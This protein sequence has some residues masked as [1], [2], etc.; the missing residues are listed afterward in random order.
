MTSATCASAARA[1][2]PAAPP[3]TPRQR[4]RRRRRSAPLPSPRLPRQRCAG[5]GRTMGATAAP[6]TEKSTATA[7]A[8]CVA[9]A[10][11]ATLVILVTL[12]TFPTLKTCA[13]LAICA[14]PSMPTATTAS[15]WTTATDP[16][17]AVARAASREAVPTRRGGTHARRS[18]SGNRL[19]LATR[20]AVCRGISQM[21]ADGRPSAR[22]TATPTMP[23]SSASGL[24]ASA[25][26]PLAGPRHRRGSLLR[27]PPRW[28]P[29]PW[30]VAL[31]GLCLPVPRGGAIAAAR[32]CLAP[33]AVA[34]QPQRPTSTT[35]TPMP[36]TT[37]PRVATAGPRQPHPGLRRLRSSCARRR[38]FPV[39]ARP[40]RRPSTC[41][42][43]T[44]GV[45]LANLLLAAHGRVVSL[46]ATCRTLMMM[47]W[48]TRARLRT[49]LTTLSPTRSLTPS[50]TAPA[51]LR[52]SGPCA[53]CPTRA[54]TSIG[55]RTRACAAVA[56]HPTRS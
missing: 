55:R 54:F 42:T 17:T 15:C 40:R 29:R 34:L 6:V 47:A 30:R 48:P 23:T 18:L 25:W 33:L 52:P 27:R 16:G 7:A 37:R 50:L 21:T 28:Q 12:V 11:L 22:S 46:P 14:G 2:P 10:I 39:R 20:H 38:H 9:L 3:G 45:L 49:T 32:L 56:P 8:V 5:D 13:T 26:A 19:R 24:A 31:Q 44:Q 4:L 36:A 51:T 41:A 35:W 1:T 53:T 43:P